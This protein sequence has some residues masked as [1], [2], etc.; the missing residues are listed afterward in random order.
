MSEIADLAIPTLPCRSID[1]TT[2]FYRK[3]GFEGGAHSFNPDYAIL[4][5]GS[6]ELHFFAHAHLI[7][8]ES[9]AGCYL[10]VADVQSL[11][12]VALASGLSYSGIPRMDHLEEKP[13]GLKE[14]AV[15]DLD[16]NLIRI[17]QII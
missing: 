7:P 6:M 8:A 16:G 5:R 4:T 12:D 14:F 13:W 11:Y 10:R 17:G 1:A 15:V 2:T 9:W 3:L